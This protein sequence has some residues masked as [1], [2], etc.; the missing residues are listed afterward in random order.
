MATQFSYVPHTARV[1]ATELPPHPFTFRLDPFQEHA[2]VAISKN[3]NVLVCA[4]TGS[5]KT[6]V[7]EYQIHHSLAQGKRVFY[8]TP[9]KSLS[10]QKFHDLK[11]QFKEASVGIMTGDIKFCPDAQIVVMT[12]EILCNL[13]Y[14]RGSATEHLGLSAS[15]HIDN[16]DAVIFDECHYINDKDRGHVWEET[17]ILLPP[18]IKLIMLSA[19]LDRPELF[20]DWIGTLKQRP[21]CLL[22]T[23]YRIVPL[24]HSLYD[25]TMS[26]LLPLMNADGEFN[27]RV[28]MNWTRQLASIEKNHDAFK[29]KVKDQRAAGVEGAIEGKCRPTSFIHRLSQ[30][31]E[32]ASLDNLLPALF[33]VL[34]RKKCEEFA[35]K[36]QMSFLT[37]KESAEVHNIINF[38]LHSRNLETVPNYHVLS[39]LMAK[40]IAFH[41][42]G[43]LPVLKEIVEILFVKGFIKVLFCTETFA[44]G[45]NMP[46][47][48]AVFVDVSKYDDAVQ[49]MR[50][51]R[52]DEY[53]QMAGRAGR[54]GMDLLGTAVYFPERAPLSLNEIRFMMKGT[55]LPVTS[56]MDF[57]YSFLLKT[58]QSS[59]LRWLKIMEDSYW[60]RQR[61]QNI[62]EMEHMVKAVESKI[63]AL[64]LTDVGKR[65]CLQ[66]ETTEIVLR[67]KTCSKEVVKQTQRDLEHWKNKHM[68]PKWDMEWKAWTKFR[69]L[70]QEK[71]SYENSLK[72]LKEHSR[73]I[74]PT[75][76]FLQ[77]AGFLKECGGVPEELTHDH[78]TLLG[79]L[80]TEVNEGNPILMPLLFLE[81]SL[82]TLSGEELVSCLA[83]FLEPN[84]KE[85][86]PTVSSLRVSDSVKTGILAI[87]T[88]MDK[89][90]LMEA[91]TLMRTSGWATAFLNNSSSSF[92][93]K[94]PTYWIEPICR[95]MAGDNL[96][97]ICADYGMFEGNLVRMVM[98]MANIIDEWQ[99][100]AIFCEHVE[101]IEKMEVVRRK[102]VRD[103][104]VSDS[105]YLH[106]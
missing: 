6:L 101:Q 83:C 97:A 90:R 98:K 86:N 87:Q 94:V 79:T 2:I 80:A 82:H 27:E 16:L 88:L 99:S 22:E 68:G 29:Q 59:S 47:K 96:S 28:Y 84:E 1:A 8:T 40:G 105:L 62:C 41:H 67:D 95:W 23:N 70:E 25:D 66:R 60:F 72:G 21:V 49:G 103:M 85:D 7:G 78:L 73:S 45:L 74:V 9:I 57:H 42:S 51:L 19:T 64:P 93:E 13:L 5:G 37:T 15:L 18:E 102:I 36:L 52:T 81:K 33:F 32:Q 20:A 92:P 10:N 43:L 106:F 56:R 31:A 24:V 91:E 65:D 104:A 12:T 48:M 89:Y 63:I 4:K 34:S 38:Y 46:A 58:L 69:E 35:S 54:R 61:R 14:K 39:D 50:V 17:L 53:I 11:H 26:K 75:M 100:L 44:V 77:R 76:N 30:F 3:H 55:R 71:V